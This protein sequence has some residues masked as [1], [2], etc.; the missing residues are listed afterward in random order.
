MA[1]KPNKEKVIGEIVLELE[2]GIER[3]TVIAKYCKKL[4]KSE[5]TVDTYWKIA[6]S[7]FSERQ[8]AIKKQLDNDSIRAAQDRLKKAILTKEERMEIA[9][10]IAKG[11]AWKV[12]STVIAPTAGDRIKAMDYLSKID[13]D[14]ATVKQDITTKGE[15]LND[16]TIEKQR[17]EELLKAAREGTGKNKGK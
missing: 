9:S 14:Y 7:R 10:K 5:R 17:F 3:K 16:A 12:G 15:S 6:N 11:E 1:I 8:E 4:Q 2:N 13:G